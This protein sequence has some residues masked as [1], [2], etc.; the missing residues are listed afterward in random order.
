VVSKGSRVK[1]LDTSDNWYEVEVIEYGRPKENSNYADRG[2]V[3][4][5]YVDVQE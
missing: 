1:I 5:K 2:W 3:Y 4:A